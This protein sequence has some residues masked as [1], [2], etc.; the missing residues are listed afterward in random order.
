EPCPLSLHTGRLIHH[1]A[2]WQREN[3]FLSNYSYRFRHTRQ[4]KMFMFDFFRGLLLFLHVSPF[5]L[6]PSSS[7]QIDEME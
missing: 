5:S 2:P 6:F 4:M 7:D 3:D 1:P